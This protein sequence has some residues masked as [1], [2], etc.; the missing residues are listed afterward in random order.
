MF[1]LR[2]EISRLTENGSSTLALEWRLILFK[3]L[4][5]K[6]SLHNMQKTAP[7]WL[8]EAVALC[9]LGSTG[10]AATI[11][12]TFGPG[13]TFSAVSYVIG[14]AV[15]Q[16]EI[17]ALFIASV[18]AR[19]DF[20]RVATSFASGLNDFTIYL[21]PDIGGQ[22]GLPLESFTGV[23]F[24]GIPSIITLSSRSHPLLI[25]SSLYVLVVSVAGLSELARRMAH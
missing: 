8:A 16:Q 24:G 14:S 7:I 13:D 2:G 18:T 4:P 20:I 6:T 5:P 15:L 10:E 1:R 12:S 11:A 23:S 9:L 21:A 3:I 19:L 25:G 17:G 22:P